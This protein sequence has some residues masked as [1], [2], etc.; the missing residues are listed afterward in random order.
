MQTVQRAPRTSRSGQRATLAALLATLL[1]VITGCG[2]QASGTVDVGQA[3]DNAQFIDNP[4]DYEGPTTAHLANSAIDPIATNPQS[5]LP[6][7]VT[8][9]QGTQVTVTDTSRI[10][11]V[12]LYGTASRTVYELGLGDHVVGRDISSGFAEIAE[13]PLVT[14]NGH[15]LNAEAILEL[16]PTVIITDTSLGPWDVMLQMRDAGIPVVAIDSKRDV[17]TVDELTMQIAEALGV[18]E[19][20]QKLAERIQ[21]DTEEMLAEIQQY[22]PESDDEKLRMMFLYVRGQAGV[23]YIFGPGSGTDSL[24]KG[25]GG[26]DVADEIGWEGMMPMTDEAIVEAQPDLVLMMTKGLESVDGVDGLMTAVPALAHTPAGKKRRIVDMSDYEVLSF[27]PNT[28]GILEALAVAIYA[29][30]PAGTSTD[31]SGTSTEE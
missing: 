5:Q 28:A 22:V 23:Y 8:D 26:I 7:T 21:A 2:G 4:K 9:A 13:K 16:A 18:P 10:L 1:F 14:E 12:D 20:G 30:D 31:E 27:G 19:E 17:D 25:V 6:V 24:I 15:D 11:A 3:L 29:P